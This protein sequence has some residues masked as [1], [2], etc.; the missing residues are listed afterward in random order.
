MPY[1]GRPEARKRRRGK[2]QG[3]RFCWPGAGGVGGAAGSA[4]DTFAVNAV[5]WMKR[6]RANGTLPPTNKAPQPD[7][8]RILPP[9]N[10]LTPGEPASLTLIPVTL[11]SAIFLLPLLL[12]PNTPPCSETPV[13]NHPNHKISIYFNLLKNKKAS[14]F[15]GIPRVLTFFKGLRG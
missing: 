2:R 5:P 1:P 8:K 12:P 14:H 4:P 3:R 7:A 11:H 9:S 13:E 6:V 10:Y 15:G